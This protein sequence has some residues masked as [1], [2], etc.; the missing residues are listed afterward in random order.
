MPFTSRRLALGALASAVGSLSF[1]ALSL[2]QTWPARPV[3][4]VVPFPPA[5]G[6]DLAARIV[7]ERLAVRLGQPVVVENKPGA[8][9]AIG[10]V[11][12][13][14]ADADGYTLL[15][16]GSSSYT[17]N[18]AVRRRLSYDPFK[19]LTPVA[20]VARAPLVLVT[21]GSGPYKTLKD[22]LSKAAANPGVVTYGT[23]GAGSA[24]H[25]AG[26]LLGNAAGVKLAPIPYKGSSEASIG[27][28]RGDISMGIDTM[29]SARPHIQ[30]GKLRALA[31]ISDKRSPLM[32]AVP[33]LGELQL[34]SAVLDAWYAVAAP[35]GLP[36]PIRDALLKAL[37]A[38]MAEPE[39]RKKLALQSMEAVLLGP[40]ALREVMDSEITRYRAAVAR[41]G[42]QLD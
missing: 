12:V 39:V 36:L 23:F 18:P 30:S 32:P 34:G 22:V 31:V 35:A 8:S 26:E 13:S 6:T 10:V 37:T 14:A 7:A 40:L 38:V 41:S 1:P 5:G 11:S 4:L 17:V 2:A 25:L 24:P 29:A 9:T 21:S 3:K 15:F 20:M 33:S 19:Q 28:I 16:S 27:T 42:I